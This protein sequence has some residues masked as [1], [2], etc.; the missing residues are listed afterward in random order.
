MG[1]SNFLTRNEEPL[2]RGLFIL[3][4]ALKLLLGAFFASHFLRELFVPFLN[5]FVQNPL[6]N[7]YAAFEGQQPEAFPYP[8]LMLYIMSFPKL[9]L[10]ALIPC[11]LFLYRLPLLAADLSLFFILKSWVGKKY[12]LRLLLFYWLSPVLFYISY[13]HGQLDAIP[14]ALLFTAL[15]FLFKNGLKASA[16]FLGLAMASK[17]NIAIVYPFFFLYLHS[18]NKSLQD[19]LSYLSYSSLAFLFPNLPFLLDPSFINMVFKNSSQAKIFKAAIPINGLNFYIIPAA[20]LMLFVRGATLKNYNRDIFMMF[21]GFAFSTILLFIT[22][23]PGWYYWLLPFLVYF[24]V[25]KE[26]RSPLLLLALQ[27]F[28]LLY[29]IIDPQANYFELLKL[30]GSTNLYQL[31]ESYGANSKLLV[32]LSF[33]C[34]QT[35]L[36]VNAA[37]IY[38]KGIESYSQHKITATPFLIGIGGNSGVGKTELSNS[39]ASIFS[40]QNV[41]LLRGDDMHKWQRG[42]EMW[43][44]YT[45]LDPKANHLHEEINS[46]KKLKA[47][48]KIARRHYDHSTGKFVPAGMLS[49][50]NLIIFEG[51]HPFYLQEQSSLYDLKIFIRPE[52]QLLFHWKLLRDTHKRGH[53]KEKIL[54]ELK[55]RETDARKYINTQARSAD[56]LIEP[57]SLSKIKEV[58]SKKEQLDIAYK[59]T[60]SNSVF[61]EPIVEALSTC[62]GLE[63][64]H[65]YGASSRQSLSLSGKISSEQLRLLFQHFVPG[66]EEI[67]ANPESWPQDS[68]GALTLIITY[69]IFEQAD[70]GN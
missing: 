51:L 62:K 37:W 44:Y 20:L 28:Y 57:K 39:L 36:L 6:S 18:K 17:T 26:G 58:G 19:Y 25:K 16:L 55:R 9:L 3:G 70:H 40:K 24:Y 13:L 61:I 54:E 10:G 8:A 30:S 35:V 22:P 41:T 53:S 63:I 23:M 7:P 65:S 47:G 31:L 59:L 2:K 60:L 64:T 69:Y 4:L 52:S 50:N 49:P 32:N 27:G 21:F 11:D 46:L 56:I 12:E 34:L 43:Q 29:F 5:Y 67:G 48:R 42:H 66:L 1:F 68:F 14:I 15:Y 45:H 33:S 38:K